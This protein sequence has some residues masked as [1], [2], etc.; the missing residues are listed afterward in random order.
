MA[1]SLTMS[2]AGGEFDAFVQA[3]HWSSFNRVLP[4]LSMAVVADDLCG[5]WRSATP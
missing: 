3:S 4:L 2:C 5:R 1:E